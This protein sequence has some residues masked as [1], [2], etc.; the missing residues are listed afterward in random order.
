MGL[1]ARPITVS[2][3]PVVDFLGEVQ[4]V[5]R[6]VLQSVASIH[7]PFGQ[8]APFLILGK[9]LLQKICDARLQWYDPL[10]EYVETVWEEWC[11]GVAEL[12][13]LSAPRLISTKFA[14]MLKV[15]HVF[16]D[17]SP[18]ANRGVVYIEKISVIGFAARSSFLA[19][20][21]LTPLKC[22]ILPRLKLWLRFSRPECAT[23]MYCFNDSV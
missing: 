4:N 12:E 17:A 9:I 16:A 18:N 2:L 1:E 23:F 19:G 8:L 20:A 6:H 3:V 14:E 5:K 11:T 22:Q 21:G 10:P 15:L 13:Q 7:D